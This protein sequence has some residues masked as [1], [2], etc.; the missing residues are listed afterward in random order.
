MK[1]GHNGWHQRKVT[2]DSGGGGGGGG[3]DE[4]AA[5]GLGRQAR[6]LPHQ[7][8]RLSLVNCHTYWPNSQFQRKLPCT[9][10]KLAS[11]LG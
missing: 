5:E 8:G 1:V 2:Y 9:S 4:G 7:V 11:E 3:R 6:P 10:V